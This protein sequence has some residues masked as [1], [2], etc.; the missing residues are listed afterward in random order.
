MKL[1]TTLF[2][3][4]F[5]LLSISGI[6]AQ[7]TV[8]DFESPEKSTNFQY[9]GSSIDGS[10][11][12]ILDNPN[13]GGIN[14]SNTVLKYVKPAGA[15][16]WAGAFSTPDPATALDFTT[17]QQICAKVWMD[18][19]GNVAIK[20][21]NASDGTPNWI[22]QVENTVINQWIELCFDTQL[23]SIEAP[24]NTASGHSY[25][26]IVLFV[27]FGIDG[28]PSDAITYIDEIVL[29][30]APVNVQ[31]IL[32]FETAETG[33]DFQYFGSSLEPNKTVIIDNP[34]PDALNSSAKVVEYK[35][36]G[37]AQTWAGA[38]TNPEP[39][40]PINAVDGGEIC[41]KVWSGKTGTVSLKLEDPV[42]GNPVWIST[43]EITEAN[44]WIEVCFNLEEPSVE[45]PNA[46]AK[47][48]VYRRIVLFFDLGTGGEGNNLTYYFDDI[49]LKAAGASKA[50][51]IKFAVDLK[52]Y[53]GPIDQ[54]HVIGT[55]NNWSLDNKMTDNGTGVYEAEATLAPSVYEYKFLINGTIAETLSPTDE[56]VTTS[57]D[58]QFTN[59]KLVVAQDASLP[60]V[61]FGSCYACGDEAN[62][63]VNLGFDPATPVVDTGVYL[64]GGAGFGAPGGYFRMTD[65]DKDNVYTITFA[66]QKGF[67]SYFTFT[68]GICPDYSCKEVI[69]GQDCAHPENFNDRQMILISKDTVMN[70]CFGHCITTGCSIVSSKDLTNPTV[71]IYPTLTNDRLN[72]ESSADFSI[73]RIT[74][75]DASGKTVLTQSFQNNN[76]HQNTQ[77]DVSKFNQ[78]FYLVGI[79][80]QSGKSE[81]L[82]FIKL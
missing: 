24:N 6:R 67:T 80:H 63:T 32:D 29:K 42:N 44:K 66:R 68:N 27:D 71:K 64:A 9:F 59:R 49:V 18:H 53:S 23:P 74:I 8:L 5:Y 65:P 73:Q 16:T 81:T 1:T 51:K 33:T 19:P 12:V 41:M 14:T 36:P 28:G 46:P 35:K 4:C 48:D 52:E 26:R 21:E 34:S 20:F 72:I 31:T 11:A 40:I 77:L 56:C 60:Q 50:R 75:T 13:K 38:F 3:F 45:A 76:T 7:V 2:F 10:L 47:G 82:K 39:S 61:C 57:P 17:N 58:G 22:Y 70:T 69:E 79:L 43:K 25:S 62:I 15:L 78:G 30:P 37:D 54:V 55:F